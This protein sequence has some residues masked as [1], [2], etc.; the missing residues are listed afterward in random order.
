MERHFEISAI[1][2]VKPYKAKA[3][4]AISALT[5]MSLSEAKD[6][7]DRC[8]KFLVTRLIR[9]HLDEQ[10]YDAQPQLDAIRNAGY[11]IIEVT[12]TNDIYRVDGDVAI[13]D[14]LIIKAQRLGAEA[15]VAGNYVLARN[16]IDA[17]DRD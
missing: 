7:I 4:N 1:G 10:Q 15:I 13:D 12:A 16:I 14:N 8:D 17:L 2:G 5:G 11:R 6:V 9:G 3:V